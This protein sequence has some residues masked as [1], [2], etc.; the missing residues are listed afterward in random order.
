VARRERLGERAAPRPAA[1]RD[2]RAGIGPPTRT[3]LRARHRVQDILDSKILRQKFETALSGENRCST[4]RSRQAT[5]RPDGECAARLRPY[6]C[7]HLLLVE[8]ALKAGQKVL[9]E[10]AQGPSRPRPRHLSFVTSSNPVAGAAATGIGIGPDEDRERHRRRQ[11]LRH[12]RRRGALP[13]EIEGPRPGARPRARRGVRDDDRTRAALRLARPRRPALRGPGQR[14]DLAR[15]HEARRPLD[16]RGDPCL[17]PLQAPDGTETDEF[18][19]H[20]SDFHHAQPVYETLPGWQ[21]PL[22]GSLPPAAQRYVE[23]VE[24][25]L[26]LYVIM[27]GTAPTAKA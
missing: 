15:A 20:Q 4:S 5:R 17:R 13:T 23:F 10:G 16:V 6:V 21:E 3:R 25:A 24:D 18:P 19:A 11:G 27:V 7:R 26:E 2:D 14:D 9:L 12:A 8:R 22:D 1:D